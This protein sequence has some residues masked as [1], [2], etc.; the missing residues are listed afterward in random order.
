M[1]A[2]DGTF[3]SGIV[4][5]GGAFLQRF[6]EVGT[7]DYLCTLHPGME[8]TIEVVAPASPAESEAVAAGV[9]GVPSEPISPW[10][11]VILAGGLLATMV[12]FT[13]GMARFGKA[14]EQHR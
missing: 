11:A 8:G 3:D 12:V 5:P 2:P 9:P 7:Y 14:A 10:I 4:D 13:I 6:D 1:T